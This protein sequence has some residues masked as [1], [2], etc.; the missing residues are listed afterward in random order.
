E[1]AQLIVVREGF[2][3]KAAGVDVSVDGAVRT[4]LKSPRFAA[5]DL[6][7]GRHEVVASLQKRIS[8]PVA[9]ELTPGETQVLRLKVGMGKPTLSPETDIAAIR[10]SLA[11]V[12]MVAS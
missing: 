7:P 8:Q 6:A 5:I 1:G 2:Y 3:G 4:Q 10:T 9:V 11:R 12:P